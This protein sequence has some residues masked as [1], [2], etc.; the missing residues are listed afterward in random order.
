MI[1][2]FFKDGFIMGLLINGTW[3]N[4]ADGLTFSGKMDS[5]RNWITKDGSSGFKAEAGRYHLYISLACPW[6]CR[7][8]IVRRLKELESI[9]SLSI[10]DPIMGENGWTFGDRLDC[11]LDT[12]NRHKYLYE[13]YARAKFDY[14]G[15]VSVPVLWDKKEETIVSNESADII[16]MFNSEFNNLTGSEL[17][18][19]PENLREAIDQVNERVFSFVNLGVYKCGFATSQQQ[20]D[21][22]FDELFQ[23]LDQLE[24]LL[25]KQHYLVGD[26]ITEADWRL[27]TTLIRF[28][29]VY[30][31]HFK[32]NLRRISDYPNL[33]KY[34]CELYEYHGIKDTVNFTQIKDHYY[35]SHKHLNP[36]GIVPRGPEL[37]FSV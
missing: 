12:V 27:F 26:Q 37:S 32:C 4:K 28:D 2:N 1:F 36:S 33:H 31:L 11:T 10:V 23:E 16:R 15:R 30:Y 29:T 5:F 14:T 18:L 24:T 19:Y 6:A 22:A 3:D 7:A 9:I 8:L 17:D 21:K 35:I 25:G 13:I 34:L 20:Y